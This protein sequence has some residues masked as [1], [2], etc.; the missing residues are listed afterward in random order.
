M[1]EIPEER[2]EESSMAVASAQEAT[3]A[4]LP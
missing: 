3:A 1:S 2:L 4:I